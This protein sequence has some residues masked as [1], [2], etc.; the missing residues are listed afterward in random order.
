[1]RRLTFVAVSAFI[2]SL[3]LSAQTVDEIVSK[4]I[5]AQGGLAKL[6]AV[7]SLR[8]SG[9]FE[10]GGMLAE[11]TQVYKRPLKTRLDITIQGM[12]MIQAY[13]GQNAWQVV[14]FTGKKDPVPMSGDELKHMK[15]QADIDGPLLDYKSKGTAVALV[16]KERLGGAEAYH[17]K[18]T[19]KDGPVRDFYLDASTFLVT[20]IVAKTTVRDAEVELESNA[21]DYRQV[22]GVMFPFVIEQRSE[23]PGVPAQ[24]ITFKKVEVNPPLEDSSFKMPPVTAAPDDKAGPAPK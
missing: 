8:M 7:Q 10:A 16:G 2:F 19:P 20:K 22:E 1:M 24:K 11:F 9:T 15:E 12:T 5:A 18:V 3:T 4:H 13:D 14:P 23:S 6:K 17:L 21:S